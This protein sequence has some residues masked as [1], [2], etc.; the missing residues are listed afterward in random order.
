MIKIRKKD[1]FFKISFNF[2]S[3]FSYNVKISN[4]H[5]CKLGQKNCNGYPEDIKATTRRFHILEDKHTL[6]ACFK[7]RFRIYIRRVFGIGAKVN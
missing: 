2:N 1:A 5:T 3:K 6:E 7:A 4:S